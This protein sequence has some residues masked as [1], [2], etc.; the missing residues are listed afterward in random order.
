MVLDNATLLAHCVIHQRPE[1]PHKAKGR[2]LSRPFC[3]RREA[4]H[5]GE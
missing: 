4:H 1:A 3:E 5:I 2:F